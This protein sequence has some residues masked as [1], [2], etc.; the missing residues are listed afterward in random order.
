MAASY[1][2]CGIA[3]GDMMRPALPALIFS[4]LTLAPISAMAAEAKAAPA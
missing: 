2:A 1:Y 4:A 3:D